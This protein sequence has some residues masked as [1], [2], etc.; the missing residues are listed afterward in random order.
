MT[1]PPGYLN[2]TLELLFE[3]ASC[4]DFSNRSI[5][6]EVLQPV[7]EAGTH[8]PTGGNLQPYSIILI[9]KP[10]TRQ[11]LA[12]LS[13]G[14]QFVAEAPVNLLF[15][16]DWHRLRRWAKLEVAPF[17]AT[18][19]FR[20]FWISFQDTV[21]CAQTICTAA[22]SVGLGSIYVGT[23]M[24]SFAEVGQLCRLP[25]GVFPVVLV[26]LGYPASKPDPAEKLGVPTVVHEETYQEL[27]D[28]QL[29][30]AFEQKYRGRQRETTKERIETIEKVCRE[31]HGKAFVKQC[32]DKIRQNGYIS[33]AQTYFG[34]HYCANTMPEGN[35]HFLELMQQQGF[36]WFKDYQSPKADK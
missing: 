26:C 8:A 24:E 21:I 23:I 17:T 14:Q 13:G 35:Q 29:L 28:S 2:P 11:R 34:L 9:E 1:V 18:S 30:A 19:S 15:C 20:Q 16:I 10:E 25:E 4:R 31:A 12:Q 5:P 27:E 3:R 22:E 7:L 32:V 6:P 33:P 36:D